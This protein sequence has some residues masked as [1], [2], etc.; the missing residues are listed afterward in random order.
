MKGRVVERLTVQL[1]QRE[2]EEERDR[3]N[4]REGMRE[5]EIDR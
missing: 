1:H 4:E 2:R 5:E 3:K